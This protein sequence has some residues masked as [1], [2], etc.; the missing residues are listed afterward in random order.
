MK[1]QWEYKNV[2]IRSHE[3]EDEQRYG[4]HPFHK[5]GEE[6]W[7]YCDEMSRSRTDYNRVFLFKRMVVD[8]SAVRIS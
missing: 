2:A 1:V 5:L 4:Q 8:D 6:G 7:E 3:V